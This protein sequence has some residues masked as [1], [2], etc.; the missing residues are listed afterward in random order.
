MRKHTPAAALGDMLKNLGGSVGGK[1]CTTI[2]MAEKMAAK[3][4]HRLGDDC[5]HI[6][7]K[8]NQAF[9]YGKGNGVI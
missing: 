2:A 8:S 7:L 4:G 5:I 3:C 1:P 6:E 9:F